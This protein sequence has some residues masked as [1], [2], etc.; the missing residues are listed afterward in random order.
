MSAIA[1]VEVWRG[2]MTRLV[3]VMVGNKGLDE[4]YLSTICGNGR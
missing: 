1:D 3:I 4:G 2:M